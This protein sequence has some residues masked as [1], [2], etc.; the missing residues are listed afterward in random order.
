[1]GNLLRDPLTQ[2]ERDDL[3]WYLE[4]YWKWPY[5]EFAERGKQVEVF[6]PRLGK[7]LYEAVFRHTEASQIVRA[8]Q[9]Y[10]AVQHQISIISD[11]P[12][13]L[14]LPWELLHDGAG[15]LAV[16]ASAPIALVRRLHMHERAAE[17][18]A[19]EPPLRI[20][21]VI[22]R[23]RGAGFVDP[24]R[25]ARELLYEVQEYIDVT[26]QVS[27]RLAKGEEID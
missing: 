14:G 19:F 4:E 11:L 22:A 23:P 10:P 7:R 16:R 5:L 18:K 26:T 3:R 15:F 21:F 9:H 27:Y 6:L 13:V 20:L 25:L 24:R 2:Q 12:R 17:S 8:W 1:M